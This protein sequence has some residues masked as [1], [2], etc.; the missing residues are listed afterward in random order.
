LHFDFRTTCVGICVRGEGDAAKFAA[1]YLDSSTIFD[2]P[3]SLYTYSW[4][5]LLSRFVYL[6]IG[7]AFTRGGSKGPRMVG[8]VENELG[9][10]RAFGTQE[11]TA[12]LNVLRTNGLL[13]NVAERF[14]R[15]F[16]LS[17][18][19]YNVL[20]ILRNSPKDGRTCSQVGDEMVA[21]VP[22][23]TRLV[24][25][26]EESGLV[27]RS[28]EQEDRRVVRVTLTAKGAELLDR[29]NGP[30]EA[31]HR[32]QLGHMSA[33]ELAELNRLLA[34]AREALPTDSPK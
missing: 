27:K 32:Q 18:A 16:G 8:H 28:R 4:D 15:D 19:T 26:L 34:K 31:L 3:E 11:Q 12:F 5:T 17:I 25:R 29:L 10:S 30:V 22:D 24:D 23:V 6:D 13:E 9:G 21:R 14:F 1:E 33:A 7:A 20:R 2:I